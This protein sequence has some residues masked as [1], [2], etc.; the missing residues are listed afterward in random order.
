MTSSTGRSESL[1]RCC[2]NK[3]VG[4]WPRQRR[5]AVAIED[6]VHFGCRAAKI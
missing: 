4:Q 1:S 5:V 3:I 2:Y 6:K